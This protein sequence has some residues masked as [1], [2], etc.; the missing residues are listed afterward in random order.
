ML[1]LP[2]DTAQNIRAHAENTYPNECCGVLLGEVS[3]DG[4]RVT[5]DILPIENA[6]E[7]DEQYH[8]FVITPED[9]MRAELTAAQRGLDV[10]GIYH[11]HPDHPAAPSDYDREHALPFYSYAIVSVAR[12]KSTDL[13][14]WE[15]TTDRT[16]FLQEAIKW[17]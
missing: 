13:T 1:T 17:Q 8:R 15:L 11:S 5:S 14:S 6:R 3:D 9:F 12:G 2:L 7:S 10:I 16:Q 4:A